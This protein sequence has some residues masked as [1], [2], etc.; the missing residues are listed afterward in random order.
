MVNPELPNPTEASSN[1]NT[2][3]IGQLAMTLARDIV[4]IQLGILSDG[5]DLPAWLLSEI[6]TQTSLR[7]K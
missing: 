5:P 6:R 3:R 4:Q 7:P 1:R 2:Q